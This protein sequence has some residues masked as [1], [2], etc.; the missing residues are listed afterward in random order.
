M[1]RFGSYS[2]ALAISDAFDEN[3]TAV[4]DGARRV[5]KKL[6]TANANKLLVQKG[7]P[8]AILDVTTR[9]G[10]TYDMLIRLLNSKSACIDLADII[11]QLQLSS[12]VWDAVEELHSCVRPAQMAA[13]RLQSPKITA[14]DLLAE[15]EVLFL[16]PSCW[17]FPSVY[18]AKVWI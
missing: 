12:D 2:L 1:P 3:S 14:G 13:A 10:S 7:L 9:L 16:F 18:I 8:K 11:P 4:L 6:R 17:L 5:V 15:F